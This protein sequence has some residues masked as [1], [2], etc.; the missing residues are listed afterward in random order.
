MS[1]K[2]DAL[3]PIRR[4]RLRTSL[5]IGVQ[6]V[7][8]FVHDP[9]SIMN[10]GWAKQSRCRYP[11]ESVSTPGDDATEEARIDHWATACCRGRR[12]PRN[13]AAKFRTARPSCRRKGGV[14]GSRSIAAAMASSATSCPPTEIGPPTAEK[15]SE[16]PHVVD[17]RRRSGRTPESRALHLEGNVVDRDLRSRSVR[18]STLS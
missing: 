16:H 8:R 9:D 12:A 14:R 5:L 7:G 18:F 17:F 3:S 11:F 2:D 6:T 1:R 13:S 15:A 4:M 10:D